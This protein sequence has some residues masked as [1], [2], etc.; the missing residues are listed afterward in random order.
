MS[1]RQREEVEE[2]DDFEPIEK[3]QELGVGAGGCNYFRLPTL[4][5]SCTTQ[6]GSLPVLSGP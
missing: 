6:M 5:P 3:L 1:C 4:E 2:V